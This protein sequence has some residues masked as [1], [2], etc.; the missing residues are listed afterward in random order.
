MAVEM[1]A[2]APAALKKA[3]YSRRDHFLSNVATLTMKGA[4]RLL[5][6]D[7]GLAPKALDDA[8]MK[9]AVA[10]YVD[11]VL[12]SAETAVEK[13]PGAATK[14][15]RAPAASKRPAKSSAKHAPNPSDAAEDADEDGISEEKD[16]GEADR[17][18]EDSDPESGASKKRKNKENGSV[19]MPKKHR[20]AASPKRIRK[21]V[22][23]PITGAVA[24]LRDVCKKAGLTYQHVF[25][26]HRDDASRETMLAHILSENGLSA[27]SDANAI[28]RVRAKV[29]LAKDLDGIDTRNVIE[30]GRRGRTVRGGTS[31][32]YA[33]RNS[34]KDDDD[35]SDDDESD[36]DDDAAS[37]DD[38]DDSYISA[39]DADVETLEAE[40]EA[41]DLFFE[42]DDALEDTP[43]V[44]EPVSEQKIPA[45]RDAE[46]EAEATFSKNKKPETGAVAKAPRRG[47]ALYSDSED[48]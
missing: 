30:G 6:T 15:N 43:V 33:K 48:E 28:G 42:K 7:M 4:R 26:R 24:K 46:A 47:G 19:S 35:E 27:R 36:D 25:M 1:P 18:S 12:A 3:V 40:A 17:D 39:S 5:E 2:S 45:A 20:N 31:A 10:K 9:A 8:E 13:D 23:M 21:D 32:E 16:D 41:E 44:A 37:D 14:E 34:D 11:R 22:P 29:E 38:D